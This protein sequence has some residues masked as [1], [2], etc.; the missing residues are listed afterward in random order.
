EWLCLHPDVVNQALL[1]GNYNT[2]DLG[3]VC[4]AMDVDEFDTAEGFTHFAMY[5]G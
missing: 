2:L 5:D 3:F 1:G 4:S